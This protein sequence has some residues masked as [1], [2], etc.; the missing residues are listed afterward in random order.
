MAHSATLSINETRSA[1]SHY[2]ECRYAEFHGANA[3]CT[4]SVLIYSMSSIIINIFTAVDFYFT[5]QA[6]SNVIKLFMAVK[7]FITLA[8]DVF[9]SG[10]Y[11]YPHEKTIR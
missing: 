9:D 6:V 1:E 4:L 8:P 2:V 7:S 3:T 5:Y 11:F 10:K